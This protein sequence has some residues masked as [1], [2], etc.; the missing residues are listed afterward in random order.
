[1]EQSA[2]RE[3][4]RPS[5]EEVLINVQDIL[6][7]TLGLDFQELRPNKYLVS[8]LHV[9]SYDMVELVMAFEDAFGFEGDEEDWD[10][11]LRTGR[12]DQVVNYIETRLP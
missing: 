5:H 7:Q 6:S 1:M 9:D 12:V 8:D 2:A 3:Q 4:P 10:K 11:V